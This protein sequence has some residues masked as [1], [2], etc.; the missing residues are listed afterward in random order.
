M[1]ILLAV[2][3]M[4]DIY[5]NLVVSYGVYGLWLIVAMA[6]LFVVQMY[7]Y[8]G[9]YARIPSFRNN[10]NGESQD[11]GGISIVVVLHEDP[12]YLGQVLP[13]MLAQQYEEFEVVLVAVDPGDDFAD[14]LADIRSRYPQVVTTTLEQDP[15]FPISNKMAYNVGIKAAHYERVILTTADAEPMSPR[16]LSYMARGFE[17]GEVVIGYCGMERLPGFANKL[18]RCNRLML[19][20][21][22]LSSAIARRPYRGILQN[23]GMTRRIY[24]E[25]KGF[26]HLNMN[27]GEDDLFIQRI[28][29]GDNIGIIMNPHAT[30][31]QKIWGDWNWW[32]RQRRFFSATFPYYP[33][34]VKTQAEWEL[35]SRFLFLV[36]VLATLFLLPVE[37]KIAAAALWVVRMAV[38]RFKMWRIRRRLGEMGLGWTLMLY[39]FVEPLLECWLAVVRRFRPIGGV[40]R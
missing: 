39:D 34:W 26:D 8:L 40:W 24:F 33:L 21:R 14:E 2:E 3:W 32:W 29:R 6:G 30:M 18:M 37:I 19:S 28:S 9:P 35:G 20:V 22:Y 38:V 17:T 13:K 31:R 15:R 4:T 10:R 12:Y 36:T 25:N 16:W 5:N 11:V 23:L 27:L 1:Q 7:Y